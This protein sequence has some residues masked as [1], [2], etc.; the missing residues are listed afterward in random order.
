VN[1]DLEQL[2][3]LLPKQRWF[4]GKD[5]AIDGID[6]V[7]E[8]V[9]E[10]GPPALV[11][12]LLE[13]GLNGRRQTYHAPLLVGEDGSVQDAFDDIDRLRMIGELM[14][15]GNVVKGLHGTIYFGGVGLDPLS[16]PGHQSIR[17][18]GVEQSNTSAVL[19]EDVIVKF[20]RR[21]EPGANP[22][23]ELNRL[24]TNE[25]FEYIPPQVGEISYE[26]E[27]DGEA[28]SIDLAM[29]QRY[30]QG[31]IDGWAEVLHQVNRLYDQID[32]DGPPEQIRSSIETR[33]AQLLDG[34]EHLGDVTAALHVTLSREDMVPDFVP[35]PVSDPDVREWSQAAAK[36]LHTLL[37][38][39]VPGL[40]E[41]APGIERTIQAFSS[42]EGDLGYKT[43][44]HA[45]YH[46]GQ[47]LRA[48]NEWLII[49][50]EGEPVRPME[51]R[52]T[53]NSPL[54]D[55]AGMLRSFSYAALVA[56]MERTEEGSPERRSMEAWAEEWQ[57]LARERF[58]VGYW[59]QSYEGSFLPPDKNAAA[60]MVDFFELDKA[61][62]E[63]GYERVYRP[64]WLSIPLR[65]I[66]QLLERVGS[67]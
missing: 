23:L 29:A 44:V 32:C 37:D 27:I 18:I 40:S 55:A 64:H 60:T 19:D 14:V 46:L 36:S 43:R 53:K 62:Y 22:D 20:F 35:E 65:G 4:G 52:R 2:K 30:I 5:R 42:L 66:R 41:L 34:I 6:V 49:D 12:A 50:F 57:T 54:R 8:I 16:P 33:A 51:L 26:G 17:A 38:E 9:V 47:V 1:I 3:G 31:A 48:A 13:V 56:V 63:L 61:I 24:L 45:D 10:D 11:F 21:V 7:D 39:R 67:L 58:L 15:H 59:R 25:G 28:V